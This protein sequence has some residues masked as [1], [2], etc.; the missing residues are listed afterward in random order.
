[1]EIARICF[2]RAITSPLQS[3]AKIT[4]QLS[5]HSEF[6]G[7]ISD[8]MKDCLISAKYCFID[9]RESDQ[10][11][12]YSSSVVGDV[13]IIK[14]IPCNCS[15]ASFEFCCSDCPETFRVLPLQSEEVF[16]CKNPNPNIICTVYRP[17]IFEDISS[18]RHQLKLKEEKGLTMGSHLWDSCIVVLDHFNH[19]MSICCD[20]PG[21][22]NKEMIGVELGAG[23]AL[24]GIQMA[25]CGLFST[26]YCTDLSS[27]VPLTKENVLLNEVNSIVSVQELDWCNEESVETFEASLHPTKLVDVIFAA[28]VLYQPDIFADLMMVIRTLSH[29]RHTVVFIAQKLRGVSPKPSVDVTLLE[30]FETELIVTASNVLIWKLMK[31]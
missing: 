14:I 23:C 26:V 5:L 28:D 27:Q 17:F 2:H 11:L 18:V 21:Y 12:N 20:L 15:S 29:S 1:M 9:G 24:T 6:S 3:G 7:I 19:L 8:L 16:F 13:C 4:I 22:G 30:D 25:K 10:T 31:L